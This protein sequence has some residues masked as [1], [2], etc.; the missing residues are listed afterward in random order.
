VTGDTPERGAMAEPPAVAAEG[1]GS[2]ARLVER[3]CAISERLD[4]L[5]DHW[6]KNALAGSASLCEEVHGLLV[7][8]VELLRALERL[9]IDGNDD[10]AQGPLDSAAGP[11]APLVAKDG[12]PRVGDLCFGAM[13]ELNRA[14][15]ALRSADDVDDRLVALE[16]AA[17]KLRRS[18]RAVA[19]GAH[20]RGLGSAGLGEKLRRRQDSDLRSALAVRRLYAGFRRSLRV[21]TE[22]TPDGVMTALRYAAGA[23]AALVSDGDYERA[24]VSDRRLLRCLQQRL[25]VWARGDK[26]LEQGLEILDDICTSADLLREINRR[27]ELRRHDAELLDALLARGSSELAASASCL[28]PLHGLDDE[29]DGLL[30]LSPGQRDWQ[31]VH[32]VLNRLRA[33]A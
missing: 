7:V 11:M 5:E 30:A 4:A 3:L 27:Q 32:T 33:G 9:D 18:V 29:L 1:D 15:R 13:L 6:A 20:A 19:D 23:L 8:T 16:T 14:L 21:A 10:T 28:S 17:R 31:L 24:R 25:L 26:E 22:Q 12:S 2:A